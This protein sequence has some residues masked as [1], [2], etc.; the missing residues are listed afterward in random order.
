VYLTFTAAVIVIL[1]HATSLRL[2]DLSHKTALTK[3]EL[4]YQEA[5]IDFK[6]QEQLLAPPQENTVNHFVAFIMATD[7]S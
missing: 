6:I 1:K 4:D 3:A 5:N 2:S 7:I